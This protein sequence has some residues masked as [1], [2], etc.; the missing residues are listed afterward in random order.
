MEK[1]NGNIIY[2][3]YLLEGL[4]AVEKDETH[5]RDLSNIEEEGTG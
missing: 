5:Q 4:D 3:N 1:P 2:R